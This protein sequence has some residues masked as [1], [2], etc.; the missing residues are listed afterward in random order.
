M[1]LIFK[2]L[3]R[4][5]A[6]SAIVAAIGA[7]ALYAAFNSTIPDSDGETRLDGLQAPVRVI[8]EANGVPHIEARS[9]VDAAQ[10]LGYVHAQERF[11]QMHLFRMVA[12]GR[13]SEMFG[14]ATVDNDIF[15]RTV[16]LAGAAEKSLGALSQRGRA[17]LSAYADGVN[18]WLRRDTGLLETS[19]PPEFVILGVEAEPWQAWHSI[20]ILKVM[21]LTLDS[22]IEDEIT[23]LALA[24]DGFS[25][26]EI[27]ELQPYGPRSS[28][29]PLPDLREIFAFR[30]AGSSSPP[31]LPQKAFGIVGPTGRSAS[32]NWVVSG[33]RTVSGGPML[34]ND[35]HLALTTPSTFYLAH[36]AFTIAGEQRHLIGASLPGTPFVLSGRTRTLAWGLTTTNLDA[37]DLYIERLKPDNQGLYATPDGWM[38]FEEREAE[39]TVSEAN[40]VNIQ[41]RRT[42][43]G[44]V[45]PDSFQGLGA[46]LPIGHVAALQWVSLAE[47]DN[48]ADAIIGVN[49]AEDVDEFVA[50]A[51]RIIAPMQSLV[52]ADIKGNIGLIAPG[53]VPLR[54]E[55]NRIAGR[56]PVPGWQALYDWNGWLERSDLPR[57]INPEIG[58]IATANANFL[59]D[60]YDHHIT[61]DWAAPYRQM[62][63][64]RLIVHYPDKHSPATM[65]GAQG[66]TYSPAL[67]EFRREALAQLQAGAGQDREMLA[68]LRDWDGRMAIDSPLPLLITAWWRHAQEAVFRDDL[69][70]TYRRIADGRMQPLINAVTRAGARDWCDNRRTPQTE[71]CGIVLSQALSAAIAELRETHGGDWRSWRWGPV[72]AA[73]GEHRPFSSISALAGLFAVT[74]ESAG[75]SYTLRRG[76]VDLDASEPYRNT[77]GSAF[78]AWYDLSNLDSAEYVIS[79]GQSGNF[80]S[81]HY[82]D[83]ADDWAYMRYVTISSQPAD[84]NEKAAGVWTLRPA[85]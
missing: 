59:P 43:H 29:P 11:W 76:K 37:Q 62:R 16:D 49:L 44:P 70:V 4:I 28:P 72:H 10:A 25:P 82:D 42:R 73:R 52:V 65:R 2:W 20:A 46:M 18:G 55:G 68:A 78:R 80:L 67:D 63:V 34:A 14:Q 53:R 19:L 54:H 60:D 75:G 38:P 64:E 6:L 66:D 1:R 74:P 35:P 3:L 50:A 9:Y 5:V 17:V 36:L 33:S 57:I 48:T 71:S 15:L 77:H 24:A 85:S 81:P 12:M 40:P 27:D 26:A 8:R 69:G 47:D 23:R 84:Y 21:A 32:N 30:S 61:F 22:N 56:M 58:A 45:L 7:G 13:L 31:A 79:T 39:I 51:E 41:I 83:L